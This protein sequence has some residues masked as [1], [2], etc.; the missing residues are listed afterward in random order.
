M[1][2]KSENVNVEM[3]KINDSLKYLKPEYLGLKFWK[4]ETQNISKPKTL[5]TAIFSTVI[6]HK[7]I[8]TPS[9]FFSKAS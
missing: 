5:K 1:V 6:P 2:W 8:T 9:S 7:L 3:F 4:S